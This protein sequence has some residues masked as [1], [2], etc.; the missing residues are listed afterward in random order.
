V[1]IH[2][3]VGAAL[4]VAVCLSVR[5]RC[6]CCFTSPSCL[7]IVWG[8]IVARK[9]FGH[10]VVRKHSRVSFLRSLDLCIPRTF[11]RPHLAFSDLGSRLLDPILHCLY[12]S[13]RIPASGHFGHIQG[14][15]HIGLFQLYPT[16]LH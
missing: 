13:F 14:Y 7:H 3:E 1:A 2:P 11:K 16:S 10:A 6:S 12:Y 8:S 4:E 15:A 9:A 5:W